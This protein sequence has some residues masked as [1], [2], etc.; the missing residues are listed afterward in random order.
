MAQLASSRATRFHHAVL[1][2]ITNPL[3]EADV[4][5]PCLVPDGEGGFVLVGTTFFDDVP[6][7][8]PLWRTKDLVHF[9][10][11]GHVFPRGRLPSWARTQ[12]WAPELHR[13]GTGW[14]CTFTARDATGRLAVGVARAERIEGPW[15]EEGR[16]LL[17]DERVGLIDA[18][19]F[20]DEDG[21]AYLFWKVDGNDL[22][23]QEPT[24]ILVQELDADAM[25]LR[26]EPVVAITNDRPWEA[27]VIE[28]PWAVRRGEHVYL[29]YSGNAFHTDAYGVG[30]ARARSVLGPWEKLEE[31]ILQSTGRWRGPGHGCVVEAFGHDCFVYHAWDREKVFGRHP[32]IP[33][34]AHIRWRRGWP[35][36]EPA[37]DR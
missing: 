37:P 4:P 9:E 26:G 21:R 24:P 2:R 1:A 20:V 14:V 10:P 32:R 35:A 12:F 6:D 16:P 31:P 3:V 30:V 11:V 28:G 15:R 18:H 27:H 13:G 34:L 7:K 19:R 36:L 8:F 29:F 22:S 33:L 17:R 23:P 5:D 25:T